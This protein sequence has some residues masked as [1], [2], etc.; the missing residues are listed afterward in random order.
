MVATRAGSWT[1]RITFA[2]DGPMDAARR[3]MLDEAGTLVDVEPGVYAW[4]MTVTGDLG[5]GTLEER[6]GRAEYAIGD[7][8]STLLA[9]P[10]DTSRPIE[11]AIETVYHD[12]PTALPYTFAHLST[13]Q[14]EAVDRT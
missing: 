14:I 6:A 4:T 1:Y 7:L 12:P 5:P 8:L 13:E 10:D 9:T 2:W 3:D 11:R